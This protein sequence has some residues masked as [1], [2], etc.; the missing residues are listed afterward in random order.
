MS[1]HLFKI[2]LMS[3]TNTNEGGIFVDS[4]TAGT[5]QVPQ[6]LTQ[7]FPN[8][9]AQNRDVAVT[10]YSGLGTPIE[11]VAAIMG[12]CMCSTLIINVAF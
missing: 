5:V 10:K 3:V 7:L 11:Q 2:A 9:S 1:D 6:Y 12:E 4:S 8:L